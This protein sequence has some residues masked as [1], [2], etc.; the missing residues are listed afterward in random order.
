[1][2]EIPN[3]MYDAAMIEG[4]SDLNTYL[5]II[6]PLSLP[7]IACIT[8]YY[9][10]G[11]WNSYMTPLIYLISESKFPLQVFLRQIVLQSQMQEMVVAATGREMTVGV[12]FNS[13]AVK[14]AALVVSTIPILAVYPFLQKYFVKGIMIGAIKG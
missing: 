1:M 9:A 10:V 7:I 14:S 13:Q 3:E 4:S 5:R 6:I 12:T 11:T 2:R 8:L